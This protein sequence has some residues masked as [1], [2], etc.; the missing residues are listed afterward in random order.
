MILGCVRM[1]SHTSIKVIGIQINFKTLINGFLVDT[2]SRRMSFAYNTM[3]LK[4]LVLSQRDSA[5][6]LSW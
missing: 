1:S 4:Q 2:R 6:Y 3:A 5:A